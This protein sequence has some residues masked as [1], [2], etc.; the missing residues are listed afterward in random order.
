MRQRR[1][2][3][4][5]ELD[6][7]RARDAKDT[8]RVRQLEQDEGLYVA[9]RIRASSDLFNYRSAGVP[10][11]GLESLEPAKARQISAAAYDNA[12]L[13]G[14]SALN[15]KTLAPGKSDDFG[16]GGS[17]SSPIPQSPLAR[18][19]M[20]FAAGLALAVAAV[21]VFERL[22]PRIRTKEEVEALLDLPVIAEIPP[23]DR[24]ARRRTDLLSRLEPMSHTAESYRVLRSAIEFS[25]VSHPPLHDSRA[26][27]ILLTSPGPSEGKTTSVANLAAV[28]AEG[29]SEVLV[30]NCDFRRPRVQHYLRS[31][32]APQQVHTTDVPGVHL[33]THVL[34]EE[35]DAGPA[36]VVRAQ[37][38]VIERARSR[39]DI[40]LLDTAPLLTTNDAADVLVTADRVVLVIS[41]GRTTRESAQRA[42]ELLG[43]RNA[44]LIGIV[45]VGARDAPNSRYYYYNGEDGY[46]RRSSR[47]AES[48][49]ATAPS[50]GAKR[51]G[52]LSKRRQSSGRRAAS[53]PPV[54]NRTNVESPPGQ[55]G[56]AFDAAWFDGRDALAGGPLDLTG[57]ADEGG[58]GT[59]GGGWG[60]K[61]RRR[62]SDSKR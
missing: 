46:L 47:T 9:A 22:D 31:A 52:R 3:R 55:M 33:I 45:L 38:K 56:D 24:G 23:L 13:E 11:I 34:P 54:P 32:D 62:M 4:Q 14:A 8:A 10:K 37:R 6:L 41:A 42:A 57:V 5:R 51:R 19:G 2:L 28:L 30:L 61:R 35:I 39:F 16:G 17:G 48:R 59:P 43:R 40:V 21:F 26:E 18:A 49:P 29:D 25:R 36:E 58:E 15:V 44:P 27:V 20:G 7:D 53:G 1:Y 12:L 50:G 60:A